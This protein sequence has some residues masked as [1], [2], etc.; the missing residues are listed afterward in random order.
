[1]PKTQFQGTR[2]S[3]TD[4]LSSIRLTID[5]LAVIDV[6][7][8]GKILTQINVTDSEAREPDALERRRQN[9]ASALNIGLDL[10]SLERV[11]SVG[12]HYDMPIEEFIRHA[13]ELNKGDKCFT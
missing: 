7:V 4:E 11:S 6:F 1:M 2:I 13:Q 5:M 12:E 10:I 3:F 8:D 9:I